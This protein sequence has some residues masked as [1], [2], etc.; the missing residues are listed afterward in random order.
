MTFVHTRSV[1]TALLL[2]GF[3]MLVLVFANGAQ[4]TE[5]PL[6][7]VLGDDYSVEMVSQPKGQSQSI[8]L[9]SEGTVD[10]LGIVVKAPFMRRHT[11]DTDHWQV[12]GC[13]S[14]ALTVTTAVQTLNGYTSDYYSS[15]SAGSLDLVFVNGINPVT[16]SVNKYSSEQR[17]FKQ[18]LV[19]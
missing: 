12:F 18:K 14:P 6:D 9:F 11:L 3:T 15:W 7:P 10:P 2:I 1:F 16:H 5:E 19:V 17:K 8:R 4:A 13:G